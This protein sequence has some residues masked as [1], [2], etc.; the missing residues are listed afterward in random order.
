[1]KEYYI[2][3]G[4][5]IGVEVMVQLLK[6]N[7]EW[8]NYLDTLY[9]QN[10]ANRNNS[11]FF[12]YPDIQIQIESN[13]I[14]L[15]YRKF[16][17]KTQILFGDV[18]GRRIYFSDVDIINIIVNSEKSVFEVICEILKLY[19]N[20]PFT[21]DIKFKIN[22]EEFY[23]KSI[24]KNDYDKG[25]LDILKNTTFETPSDLII[26][27]IDLITLISLIINKE[28]LVDHQRGN[29]R[30]LRQT[31]KFY[32][33]SKFYKEGFYSDELK[34][35]GYVTTEKLEEVYSNWNDSKEIDK[36]FDNF[37]LIMD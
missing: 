21:E 24:I 18:Y 7:I 23:Y 27:Y 8:L 25:K 20:N 11:K 13:N 3:K 4:Y 35:L 15:I 10:A 1:M 19:I 12:Y 37:T 28:Y 14:S 26:K 2:N 32:I 17:R 16:Y 5:K 33:L 34:Q 6:K 9:T 22:N 31:K 36:I 30:I 29:E